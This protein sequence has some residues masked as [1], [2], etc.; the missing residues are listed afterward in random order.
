MPAVFFRQGFLFAIGL[1][2]A[3][4]RIRELGVA[5]T[6]RPAGVLTHLQ[7]RSSEAD[8][9][10]AV[11][12]LRRYPGMVDEPKRLADPASGPPTRISA[13]DRFYALRPGLRTRR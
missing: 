13:L 4:A 1:L 3:D 8:S 7:S 12:K 5:V 2:R 6:K 9:R 11:P 10:L